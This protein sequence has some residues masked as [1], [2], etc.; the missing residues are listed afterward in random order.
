MNLYSRHSRIIQSNPLRVKKR[1]KELLLVFVS[2]IGQLL[3]WNIFLVILMGANLIV[4]LLLLSNAVKPTVLSNWM[5]LILVHIV[6]VTHAKS[7]KFSDTQAEHKLS[8]NL[9]WT[10]L[11]VVCLN[12][13]EHVIQINYF[14]TQFYPN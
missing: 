2:R 7:Q 5:K 1:S 10:T 14:F 11:K 3:D 13:K 8:V 6:R 9:P 4:R 12:G